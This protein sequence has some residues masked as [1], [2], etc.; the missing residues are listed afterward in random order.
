MIRQIR[1]SMRSQKGF[2][3]VELM[4]VVAILGILAAIAIPKFAN[5]TARANTAKIAAD[6]RT[7]DS[8][9]A[10]Y[11]ASKGSDPTAIQGA[12]TA[13]VEA[14]LLAAEP[15]PPKGQVFISSTTSTAITDT[16]YKF[17]ATNGTTLT[18]GALRA[19]FQGKYAEDFHE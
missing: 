3:L 8:A 7:I 18:G 16:T 1:K 9:I 14:G 15:T 11:Q 6:L 17:A 2:T 13:L 12:G 19:T 5:S 4:V 10:M